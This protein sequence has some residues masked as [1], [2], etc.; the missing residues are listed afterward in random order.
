[1]CS[2][3][4]SYSLKLVSVGSSDV[5]Q[6]APNDCRIRIWWIGRSTV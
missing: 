3:E 2:A 6:E 5:G 4:V 1:M